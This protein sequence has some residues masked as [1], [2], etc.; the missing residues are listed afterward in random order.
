MNGNFSLK[1]SGKRTLLG[2]LIALL[3]TLSSWAIARNFMTTSD[4]LL[5]AGVVQAIFGA[6]A[7]DWVGFRDRKK[8]SEV[9][10]H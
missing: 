1:V 7:A 2:N 6:S 9:K 10:G 5:L 8:A 3:P 4:Q